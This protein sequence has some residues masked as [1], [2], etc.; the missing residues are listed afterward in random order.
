VASFCTKCGAAISPDVQFCT[1]CGAPTAAPATGYAAPGYGAPPPVQ[2]SQPYAPPVAAPQGSGGSALKIILIIVAVFVG[3]GVL[4]VAIFAFSVW[5]I[6]HAVRVD[7]NGESVTVNTPGGTIS[8]STSQSYSASEMGTDIYPGALSVRGGAKINL[9]GSSMVT[10]VYVTSDSKD[11]VLDFYKS[12]MGGGAS[13]YDAEES[14]VLTA[15][16]GDKESVMVTI[17]SKPSEADGKT[18]IAIM[19]TKSK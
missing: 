6:A 18:K 4:G 1:T 15:K 14:A 16:K 8:S 12:R 19:H 17:S 7:S 5:H 11:K 3:L 9:P 2:Y 13:V 10:A